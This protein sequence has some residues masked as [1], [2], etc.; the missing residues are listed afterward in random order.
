VM[1]STRRLVVAGR[2]AGVGVAVAALLTGCSATNPATIAAPYAASDGTAGELQD[3]A[4]GETVKLRNFLIVATAKGAAGV[5]AGAIANDGARPV[6]VR[7]TV[8]DDTDPDQ[9]RTL[10]EATVEV[11]PGTLALLGP[12]GTALEVPE[13]TVAPGQTLVV[14]A[15]TSAGSTQFPL[16]VMAAAHEYATLTPTTAPTPSP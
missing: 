15:A 6:S 1:R 12:G 2:V 14:S 3:A 16:P 11:A 13:V 5:V 10:G 7:I 9:P 8:R 4:T